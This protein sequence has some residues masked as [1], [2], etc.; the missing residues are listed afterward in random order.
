MEKLVLI[1]GNS[2]I[3]RAFYA[4]PLLTN[5][6]GLFTNA[7]YGFMN[8]FMKMV[9]DIKPTAVVCA[10]DLK[11]PTFRHKLY[12]EYKGTRKPMP[13]EL[14]PQIPLLKEL[15]KTMGV[16]VMEKEGSEAD[17][18]IGTIAKH[19]KVQTV[20]FTG[21][22]DSFQLVDNETEV[23]FTKRGITDVEVYTAENFKEKTGIEPLQIID[24]KALMGDSSDNIPGVQGVG[25]KTALNLLKDYPSVEILYQNI[26]KI[27]GKLQEKLIANK[28]LCFLS[29]TLATIDTDCGVDTDVSKMAFTMPLPYSA[30]KR[31]TELG[32]RTL[33][34]KDGIFESENSST[35]SS[36]ESETTATLDATN[37]ADA[38]DEKAENI[39]AEGVAIER[40]TPIQT[41]PL[42]EK[43]T[44]ST[45]SEISS[46]NFSE[47]TAL[48]ISEKAVNIYTNGTEY[49]AP[50][51]L[52]LLDDGFSLSDVLNALSGLFNG[53]KAVIVYDVKWLRHTLKNLADVNL[54]APIEDV[55]IIKYLTDYTGGSETLST[56]LAEYGE[57][58][59][60]NP[61]YSLY[62]VYTLL[63]A[64][65]K[66]QGVE[67]LY[68]EVE[69]PLSTLLFN[70]EEWGFKVD[71]DALYKTGE[72][73]RKILDENE[74]LI[75][76][77]AG[78]DTLNVNSP[79]Q[80]GVLLF[81]KLKIAKGK[82][83]KT[84][85]STSADVLESLENAHPIVPLILKHRRVQKLYST[86]IE[87]FKP[88]IDKAT[89][90][91]HT[92]FNQTVTAT[93][94]L[95]SKEPNLQNI[96]VRDEEGKELRKFF[97]P[98]STDRVLVSADY[99]QIELRL[100]AAFSNCK[101]LIDA[102]NSGKDI[103]TETASKV[104]NTPIDK[105]T[106]QMR[107]GAKAVN[108]GIIYGMSEYGLA[109]TINVSPADARNYI[110]AYFNEY[111]EVKNYMDD[112]VE[113]AKEHGYVSTL[114]GRRRYIKEL[115]SPSYQLRQFGERV[116]MNMPL[117]GSS[118]DIIKVAMLNVYNR[119]KEE[120][121]DA[122]LIL[123]VHDE[124]I[125]DC[126][127]TDKEKAKKILK[128][129]MENAVSLAVKLTVGM[130]EG[131]SWFDAK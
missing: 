86:Y 130:G 106:P 27:K 109:K 53:D 55:A 107:S 78:D 58:E 18:I 6:D 16:C 30:K 97:V 65:L 22:K 119:L 74:I 44:L 100:L 47:E 101:G 129:E 41:A 66:E 113:F 125:L 5:K 103:H 92:S 1:D 122:Y 72:N 104:F 84:G 15:L 94:R 75:R 7:V 108:F 81:E 42:K 29:K 59:N 82:K 64:K 126:A 63:L 99:S 32:F 76:E 116:A 34:N 12:T 10:F 115:L 19:T 21:D 111:P 14:R 8:M 25:E 118:A 52:S 26:D 40:A 68:R 85:Y 89:G 124:L 37:S 2:L 93:G 128:E 102:F 17:D 80:L 77:L 20:I 51:R 96:P 28:D 91:V 131:E 54:T 3:N 39:I 87:G 62:K 45:L 123:Q 69:L 88:L 79:K 48:T 38:P 9:A 95:S 71:A 61:A 33:V 31:F 73:Y 13:E 112:N 36:S 90:L 70:M 60:S 98:R 46:I 105:V 50:L 35:N 56:A 127:V 49:S 11:A 120:N 43:V 114:L 121:V 23:H 24:L 110:S 67:K 83:T 117:Q 4:M 57:D